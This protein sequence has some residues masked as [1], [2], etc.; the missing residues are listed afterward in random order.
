MLPSMVSCLSPQS[1]TNHRRIVCYAIDIIC[2]AFP[3]LECVSTLFDAVGWSIWLTTFVKR[4]AHFLQSGSLNVFTPK[5]RYSHICAWIL[6]Q[7]GEKEKIPL[8]HGGH[9]VCG[10]SEKIRGTIRRRYSVGV[11]ESSLHLNTRSVRR[12]MVSLQ[13]SFTW[14]RLWGLYEV[15]ERCLLCSITRT[16]II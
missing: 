15:L 7:M 10:G 12:W 4:S 13:T 1:H 3:L 11:V 2:T 16:S 9:F 8:V 5:R 14:I 6:R